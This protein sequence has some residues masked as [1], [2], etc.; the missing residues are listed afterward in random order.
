MQ[1]QLLQKELGS[2]ETI[3]GI[4]QKILESSLGHNPHHIAAITLVFEGLVLYSQSVPASFS[5]ATPARPKPG[6]HGLPDFIPYHEKDE[7]N[8]NLTLA[9]QSI[10]CMPQ[11]Q[12]LSHEVRSLKYC[13]VFRT[14]VQYYRRLE[15]TITVGCQSNNSRVLLGLV[16]LFWQCIQHYS[17]K[18]LGGKSSHPQH[19]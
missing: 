15:S 8:S 11:Y 13:A 10:S 6:S 4:R 18:Q 7:T 9:Y 3:L 2:T 19:L 5:T 14:K 17:L 12:S 16:G 1:Y